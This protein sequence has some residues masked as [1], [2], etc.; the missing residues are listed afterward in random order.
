MEQNEKRNFFLLWIRDGTFCIATALSSSSV[1]QAFFL[2]MGMSSASV[3]LYT[4]FTQAVYLIFSVMFAGIA[5][6][7]KRTK[8]REGLLYIAVGASIIL[9]MLLCFLPEASDT[10][11]IAA[12]IFGGLIQ[13][14]TTV[15]VVFDYK[16]LCEVIPLERYSDYSSVSGIII[17]IFGIIPGFVLP[18]FYR[19]FN[20]TS[21]TLAVFAIAGV[22]AVFSGILNLRLKPIEGIAASTESKE[23][24]SVK[25]IV[26]RRDF[27][28]LA[29]PNFI[30]GFGAGT[31]A[32]IPLM[33]MKYAGIAEENSA[34][35]SGVI[36]GATFFS[37]ALYGIAR[38]KKISSS[39]LSLIGAC[40]FL[41][42]CISFSGGS[43]FFLVILFF[44]Y[45]GYNLT[46]YGI[47]DTI[48]RNVDKKVMSSFHTWRMALTTLGTV[49]STAVYSLMIDSSG[50]FVLSLMGGAAFL[51]C[52]VAYYI[53]YRNK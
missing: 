41:L 31:A 40:L 13:I 12:F 45:C 51:I 25:D 33:A 18:L 7:G 29:I 50:G 19:R 26:T 23:T 6:R 28:V 1:L 48:Y 11:C 17:G 43:L 37:C 36:N 5:D 10:F 14:F 15:R 4:S 38:K 21:V 9:Q 44:A 2:K 49:L 52:A 16:L 42:L 34:L 46:C 8:E 24:V 20:Y 35:V 39:L 22:F 47:P 3:S 32:I 27:L 30:R 53:V